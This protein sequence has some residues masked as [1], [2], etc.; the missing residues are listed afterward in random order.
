MFS[1]FCLSKASVKIRDSKEETKNTKSSVICGLCSGG[2][3]VI[4]LGCKHKC[5]TKCF[6][7]TRLC[8]QCENEK[9]WF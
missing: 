3:S 4:V 6:H 5:C 1:I 2:K 7:K 8:K 9:P